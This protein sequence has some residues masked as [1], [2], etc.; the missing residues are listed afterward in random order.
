[1]KKK[2]TWG[3]SKRQTNLN[4][5]GLDFADAGEVLASRY[6]LD[7]SVVRNGEQRLQ[8]FSYV[9]HR[10]AVLS[11]VHLDRNNTVRVVS[12]RPASQLESEMYY[13]WLENE[14][15]ET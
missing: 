3:E 5:H 11:L 15:N 13:E 8:S 1:M 7:V 9:M 2:L 4:K 10:L 12:F 6:R 14:G